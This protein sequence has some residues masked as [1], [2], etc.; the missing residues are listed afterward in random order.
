MRNPGQGSKSRAYGQKAKGSAMQDRANGLIDGET[1]QSPKLMIANLCNMYASARLVALTTGIFPRTGDAECTQVLPG[2]ID[3]IL[4]SHVL[5]MIERDEPDLDEMIPS[6]TPFLLNKS[7]IL[8][9]EWVFVMVN[10]AGEK[11]K[12]AYKF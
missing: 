8:S 2:D 12:V 11:R 10:R 4:D 1:Y 9:G 3:V 6:N 7:D 5:G